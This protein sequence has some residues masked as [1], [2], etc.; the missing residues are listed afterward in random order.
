MIDPRRVLGRLASKTSSWEL[1]SPGT[2]P[3]R[4]RPADILVALGKVTSRMGQGLVLAKWVGDSTMLPEVHEMLLVRYAQEAE[5][6]RWKYRNGGTA[7]RLCWLA[8]EELVDPNLCK[9]CGGAGERFSMK[10]KLRL[11][12]EQCGGLGIKS[13]SNRGRARY[14]HI[15]EGAWR[16]RWGDRYLSVSRIVEGAHSH[17][18]GI[19]RRALQ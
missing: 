12:C 17:A 19:I 10:R 14:C 11:M 5:E 4:M 9:R 15:S 3:D 2:S 7:G 13:L 18:L 6:R 1:V 16:S 8:I